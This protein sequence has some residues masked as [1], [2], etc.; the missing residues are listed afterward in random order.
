MVHV[1]AYLAAREESLTQYYAQVF[2]EASGAG[3]NQHT[4]QH[5]TQMA[6]TQMVMSQ[7]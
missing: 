1:S 7:V 4:N 6:E 3:A 5:M 2:V